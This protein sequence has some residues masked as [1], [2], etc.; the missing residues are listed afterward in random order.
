MTKKILPIIGMH[1]ASCAINIEFVLKKLPG[2][3]EANV[4]FASEK[5]MIEYDENKVSLDEIAAA[6]EKAGEYK[7][8]MEEGRGVIKETSAPLSGGAKTGKGLELIS[9][10]VLGMDSPHCAMAVE[11]AV[12]SLPGIDKIETD[13]N[14]LRAKVVYDPKQVNLE[15]IKKVI[16]DV[17]Y[18]PI[19]EVGPRETLEDREKVEREK[20]VK[21][22]KRKIIV[23]AILSVFIFLGSFPQWFPWMP[24]ILNSYYV[25]WLLTTPVQFWVGAQFYRG[26]LLVV[27]YRTADMNTLIA[28]GTSVA[29][30]YSTVVTFAPWVLGGVGLNIYFDT[31]AIIVTL[32]LLGKFLELRAKGQAS[33][34]IRKLMGLQAKEATVLLDE[35]DERISK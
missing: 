1:C 20:Q 5:L 15:Q 2:I 33:E 24:K 11:K 16:I 22:I 27:K 26:L 29:Y 12:K 21:I 23:G 13:F 9:L 35:K 10:K 8:I 14:N 4:N 6:V 18:K 7:L 19:E 3:K 34:A 32:I 28:L 31:S 25:L 17:G 30:L